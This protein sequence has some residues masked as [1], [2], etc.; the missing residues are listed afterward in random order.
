MKKIRIAGPPGTGKTKRLVEIFYDCIQQYSATE[1]IVTSHTNTAADEIR[2]RILDTKNI[3]EYQKEKG[4]DIFRL[5]RESRK[6]LEETVT[7]IHKYCKLQI[8]K[9]KGKAVVFDSDDYNNLKEQ[10]PLFDSY[11]GSKEFYNLEML[12]ARHPFFKFHSSARDNGFDTVKYY[13]TLSFTERAEYKYTI[14]ELQ[15]LE[16]D[17]NSFKSNIK[18][19]LRAERI[20][21]FQDMVE[22]FT[23]SDEIKSEDLG[24]KLLMVD[25]AQDSSVLQ[26]AAEK[27]MAKGTE[28]FYKAGDP[29]QSIFEFAGANPHEFHIE[30]ADPEEELKQGYR[31]PRVIND[32]C[33]DIIRPLW[34]HYNYAGG[35][36][37]WAPRTENG[38][39]VEGEKFDMMNLEQDPHLAELDKRLKQTSETFAF[40]YRGNEPKEAI[41][42]L[43]KLGVPFKIADKHNRFQFKYPAA[44]IKN[45]REFLKLIREKKKLTTASIKKILKNTLP[46][47]L[48][49]N[50][51]EANLEEIDKGHHDIEWLI[52]HQFLNPIVK[53]SDD[54][55]N[56]KK[57]NK[58]SYISTIEMKN[59]IRRVVEYDSSGN[60]EKTPRIF[61]EN[62]HT[63]KGKEFDNCVVDLTIQREETDFT[64][65][66][67]KYVA[68]SRAKKT[69]WLIKSKNGMTL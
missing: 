51:S 65:R 28:Y 17:Y 25:E 33:K 59:F 60:L 20:L 32:Y 68:C 52:K 7:T 22:H 54:F 9:K 35:G 49:K 14:T 4:K 6:T 30:F 62:I 11:T 38:Q 48:G 5:V 41:K 67:I 34:K 61:L 26:R 36:R 2:K 3:Q 43:T 63:I 23:D 58:S 16:K 47:Y 12:I 15:K 13:R 69:L 10:H 56:I 53:E 44:D 37:V 40:T 42:Y 24:I 64:K 29:D 19:N 50:Y 31:C 27:K 21:D 1:M 66:R 18:L 57:I 39:V 55:Q 45:Q 46:E 8:E